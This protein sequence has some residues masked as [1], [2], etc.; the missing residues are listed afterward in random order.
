MNIENYLK[1]LNYFQGLLDRDF[2]EQA[3]YIKCKMGCAK[4]CKNGDYP[5]SQV[6][7]EYLKQA[8]MTLDEGL[9]QSILSKIRTLIKEKKN[10]DKETFL[11][12]CP[13]L[14]DDVCSVYSNRGIICRTF[15]LIHYVDEVTKM[16][17]PFCAF[18][19]LNYSDVLDNEKNIITQEKV[20]E[21]G[22]GV[23][24]KSF[25]IDYKQVTNDG[26][27]QECGF[28]Y[29]EKGPLLDILEKD[30]YFGV[31]FNNPC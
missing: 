27:A 19:G 17:V 7:V 11:H 3:P 18:Q 22:C 12:E 21:F 6:E 1:F 15:G 31:N 2:A 4:C 28:S 10:S 26:I 20:D 9:K 24:P 8:F 29:G 30:D 14:V 25:S 16:Q 13:F 5:F 23:E